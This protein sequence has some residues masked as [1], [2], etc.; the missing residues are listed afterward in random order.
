MKGTFKV[1]AQGLYGA[2]PES[3]RIVSRL[4]QGDLVQLEVIRPRNQG[5]L[6]FWWSLIGWMVEQISM[7]EYSKE[8]LSH[9]MKIRCGHFTTIRS[10]GGNEYQ[11]PNSIA[12]H[13]MDLTEDEFAEITSKALRVASVILTSLGQVHWS[14]SEVERCRKEFEGRWS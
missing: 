12:F 9:V 13:N 6:R 4:K 3:V 5:R 8:S 2:D 7:D 1:H 10:P 14:P 11:I